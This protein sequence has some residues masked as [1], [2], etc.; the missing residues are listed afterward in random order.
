MWRYGYLLTCSALLGAACV[1][2]AAPGPTPDAAPGK[3]VTTLVPSPSPRTG[4]C[5]YVY[6]GPLPDTHCT[7]GALNPA[8]TPAT[9]A[10]TICMVGYTATVRPPTSYTEPL[11]RS[12]MVAYGSPGSISSYEEDH[13]VALEVG[14]A[15][16]DPYNLWPQPGAHNVKD[17]VEGRA[18]TAICAGRMTLFEVQ[19]RMAVDWVSLAHTLGVATP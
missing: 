7:P 14:G 12:G 13:L 11:K 9:L 4:S 6:P 5:A 2:P 17:T 19:S 18:N 8:V 10:T 16:N 3:R 1:L 15:P